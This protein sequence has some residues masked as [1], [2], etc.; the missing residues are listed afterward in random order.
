MSLTRDAGRLTFAGEITR[1]FDREEPREPRARARDLVEAFIAT[2]GVSATRPVSVRI[3]DRRGLS[4]DLT[5]T[6]AERIELFATDGTSFFLE[7]DR[8]TRIVVID[9]KGQSTVLLAIEPNEG[10]E[11]ADILEAGRPG[12]RHDPLAL[13]PPVRSRPRR[14]A[15]PGTRAGP[16]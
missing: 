14:G 9:L 12:R 10:F 6:D 7:P 8:T 3:G 1:V 2:D 4:A 15:G 11:L 13:T 16:P 5:P